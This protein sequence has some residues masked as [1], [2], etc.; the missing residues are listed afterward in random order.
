MINILIIRLSSLGDIIHTYPMIADIKKNIP[1]SSISWLVDESFTDLVSLNLHIDRVISIPLRKY[2]RNKAKFIFNIYHWYRQLSTTNYDYIIDS[3]GL[4]KSAILGKLFT[5]KYYG[6][7][8]NSAREGLASLLYNVKVSVSTQLLA[9]TKNRYLASSIF[10]YQIDEKLI[11]FG[12]S[13]RSYTYKDYVNELN[14][15][16]GAYIVLFIA[17]SKP[18]KQYSIANW[19]ILINYLIKQYNYSIVIPY[20]N[21]L[22]HQEALEIK[23]HLESFNH[24]VIVP[25]KVMTF[26]ELTNIISTAKFVFGVDTGLIHLANALNKKLIALYVD[27][28]PA[29]TG[30]I[31]SPIAKNLGA[32]NLAPQPNEVIQAFEQIELICD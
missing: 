2:K 29:K 1:N 5:G 12:I 17:T 30:V 15:L 6:Y 31:E 10:G 4:F 8:F 28:D 7:T 20:G 13:N 21:H 32:K 11:D 18:S 16:S 22:E 24:K 27:S 3:Q 25:S 26:I 23:Q 14:K 19:L 9:V